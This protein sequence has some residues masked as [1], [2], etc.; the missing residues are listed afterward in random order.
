M[1]HAA[2]SPNDP[3]FISHHA[4]IDC[5]F[6][7]WLKRNHDAT[8]P[9]GVTTHGHRGNDFIVPFFPLFR[10]SDMFKVAEHFGYSCDLESDSSGLSE[11]LHTLMVWIIEWLKKRTLV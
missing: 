4:M 9:D 6:E 11:Q 5:I 10:H 2:A 7:E 3:I 8:Y 1:A